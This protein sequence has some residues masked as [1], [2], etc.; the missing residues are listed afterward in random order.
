MRLGLSSAAAPDAS[1]DD[2]AAAC[3]ARGLPA[4]ELR[5]GDGHGIDADGDWSRAVAAALA[6]AAT[7]GV[8]IAG[9]RT[10]AATDAEQ[11]A[12]LSQALGA[13]V[14]VS[15]ECSIDQR[16][17]RARAIIDAGGRALALATGQP[18]TW[19]PA[20]HAA[21]L[22]YGWEIDTASGDVSEHAQFVLERQ[23]PAL[24]YIRLIGGGPETSMQEGRGIG[25]LMG[26]LALAGYDGPLVLA[27]SSTRYRVAW[28]T[29]L[30]R[31]GGWGCGSTAAAPDLVRLPVRTETG[32]T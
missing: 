29:W 30:G 19:H 6:S 20:A 24:R 18:A 9:Y 32:G 23:G 10:D 27:P 4:L 1:L 26:T 31:R 28:E 14:I 2:L 22:D 21:G 15:C 13:P 5:A 7:A 16:A 17:E 3:A 11:L 12:R 25:T 8:T